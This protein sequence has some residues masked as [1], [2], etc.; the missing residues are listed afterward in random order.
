MAKRDAEERPVEPVRP[1]PGSILV[2]TEDRDA[3]KRLDEVLSPRGHKLDVEENLDRALEKLGASGYDLIVADIDPSEM[4]GIQVLEM[5]KGRHPDTEIVGMTDRTDLDD[6]GDI[7]SKGVHAYF[8]PYGDPDHIQL[9][10]DWALGQQSHRV[11]SEELET[12]PDAPQAPQPEL[13]PDLRDTG[14]EADAF[15]GQVYDRFGGLEKKL[16]Q[17]EEHVQEQTRQMVQVMTAVDEL[18][19]HIS[20]IK[21]G[22]Q[23]IEDQLGRLNKSL[24]ETQT[25][26]Q[27]QLSSQHKW[28]IGMML[29][30]W[31]P[32]IVLFAL[33]L[34]RG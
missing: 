24:R 28:M 34:F 1:S 25:Q 2:I 31:M 5:L 17:Q 26:L 30:T 10:V 7:L 22:A 29:A 23:G 20:Q 16:Q 19:H 18:A 6:A 21:E 3:S 32:L 9:M 8:N 15:F 27:G 14:S 33:I 13:R 11:S 12:E 4:S